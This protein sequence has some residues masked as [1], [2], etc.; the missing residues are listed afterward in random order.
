MIDCSNNEVAAAA[1]AA[2]AVDNEGSLIGRLQYSDDKFVLPVLTIRPCVRGAY[3]KEC[4]CLFANAW[5][6]QLLIYILLFSYYLRIHSFS[7]YV[8]Y[9]III[10]IFLLLLFKLVLQASLLATAHFFEMV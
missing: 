1:A 2:A 5:F 7:N 3:R 6:R 4:C 10:F 8:R 9:Y